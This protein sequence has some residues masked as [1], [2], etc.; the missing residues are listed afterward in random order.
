M[1]PKEFKEL[2]ESVYS[3]TNENGEMSKLLTKIYDAYDSKHIEKLETDKKFQE[4]TETNTN[5][6]DVNEK[7]RGV[8]MDLFLKVGSIKKE[9]QTPEKQEETTKI[10]EVYG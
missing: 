8:N 6:L 7:L 2:L 9:T 3:T 5:L 4:I 1:E 10:T